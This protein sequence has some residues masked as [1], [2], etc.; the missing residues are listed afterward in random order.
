[1]AGKSKFIA[2]VK[3]RNFMTFVVIMLALLC[4]FLVIKYDSEANPRPGE[5]SY[6]WNFDTTAPIITLV[7][8]GGGKVIYTEIFADRRV[9]RTTVYTDK[10]TK[11]TKTGVLSSESLDY[12]LC[13]CEDADIA[14]MPAEVSGK[15]SAP[16]YNLMVH[17]KYDLFKIS[18]KGAENL[19]FLTVCTAVNSASVNNTK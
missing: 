15:S 19:D 8:E 16:A 17:T 5:G 13:I 14:D 2:S 7:E 9:N 3:R 4:A 18:G 1:M 10:N 6:V 11:S 12:L